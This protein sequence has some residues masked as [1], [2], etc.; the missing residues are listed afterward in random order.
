MNPL[1]LPDKLGNIL[2]S[3]NLKKNFALLLRSCTPEERKT[4]VQLP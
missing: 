2:K 1:N 3:F 4:G